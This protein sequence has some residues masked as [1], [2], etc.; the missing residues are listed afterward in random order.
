MEFHA[1]ALL[2]TL[3]AVR[4]AEVWKVQHMF[5]TCLLLKGVKLQGPML[6]DDYIA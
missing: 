1:S 5:A 4:L 3:V 2:P 6:D